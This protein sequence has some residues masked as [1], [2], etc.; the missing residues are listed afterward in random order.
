MAIFEPKKL[1]RAP[2]AAM[3][4]VDALA[5]KEMAANPSLTHAEAVEKVLLK[6][7]DLYT[8]YLAEKGR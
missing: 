3:D 4:K 8:A 1:D 6:R 2:S 5:E 7:K